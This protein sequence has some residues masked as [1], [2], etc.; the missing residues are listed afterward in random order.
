MSKDFKP[1]EVVLSES[2]GM[3]CDKVKDRWDLAPWEL[4]KKIVESITENPELRWDLLPFEPL[5]EIVDIMSYGAEKYEPNNWQKVEIM[6]Y[7]SA[8]MRHFIDWFLEQE[9]PDQDSGKPHTS[10]MLTNAVF[11]NYLDMESFKNG[12]VIVPKGKQKGN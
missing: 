9:F 7:F 3:K 2:G 8:F 10:H 5:K 6:R 1:D 4:I 12:K 11:M